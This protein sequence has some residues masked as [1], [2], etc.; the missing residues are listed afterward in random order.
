[1]SPRSEWISGYLTEGRHLL[2]V[3][4]S[5]RQVKCRVV[6]KGTRPRELLKSYPSLT[7]GWLRHSPISMIHVDVTFIIA[8]ALHHYWS[9]TK[10][11]NGRFGRPID[12]K[13]RDRKTFAVA[14]Q[15]YPRA[16]TFK[17][18]TDHFEEKIVTKFYLWWM[19]ILCLCRCI[20]LESFRPSHKYKCEVEKC[21]RQRRL[22]CP[23]RWERS[24]LR[25]RAE[26]GAFS[27]LNSASI[28]EAYKEKSCKHPLQVIRQ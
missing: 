14:D 12:M 4:R 22:L 8:V 5:S 19:K 3:L 17:I 6:V 1:M 20:E 16:S 18:K 21:T 23:L 9:I 27:A 15:K 13:S 26:Q 2:K 28:L 24:S 11:L 25:S 10:D 7:S